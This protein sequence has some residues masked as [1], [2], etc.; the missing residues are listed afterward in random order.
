MFSLIDFV[1]KQVEWTKVTDLVAQRKVLLRG[2][3]AYVP[4]SQEY[5]LVAAEFSSRLQRGL[6][7]RQDL[8]PSRDCSRSTADLP[9]TASVPSSRR[10]HCRGWTKTLD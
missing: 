6:E 7:V 10:K 8:L 3:K 4:Q 5:S 9:V 2:G 1:Y